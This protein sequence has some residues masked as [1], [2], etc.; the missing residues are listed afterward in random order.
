M[1]FHLHGLSFEE[2]SYQL[3][4]DG[5]SVIKPDFSRNL[6]NFLPDL[7][8]N[9]EEFISSSTKYNDDEYEG[10]LYKIITK[11]NLTNPNYK[12]FRIYNEFCLSFMKALNINN[13]EF[14]SMYQTIDTK[15]TKH[16]AQKPHFD[17]L[18]ALK[19]ML[20]LNNLNSDNGAFKLSKGSHHW[21][22]KKLPNNRPKF[23]SKEY[24]E[25][26]RNLPKYILNG[27]NPI[28]GDAGTII[29]FYTDCVH[30]QGLVNKGNCQILRSHY[31]KKTTFYDKLK[32][33]II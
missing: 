7:K 5:Y 30:H 23:E 22:K 28:E 16:I 11:K 21:V 32:R 25:Y 27:L 8:S 14:N 12:V 17:R 20:Y 3:L 10:G 26:S 18:P 9:T 6:L 4:I 31:W 1:E 33:K 13:H 2:I 29:I 19:F 24:L 15:K